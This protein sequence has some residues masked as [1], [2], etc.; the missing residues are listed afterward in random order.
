[1]KKF[2]L[3]I[4]LLI[5][6]G[7]LSAGMVGRWNFEGNLDNTVSG[8]DSM[9]LENVGLLSYAD[10]TIGGSTA[11][12][13]SFPAFTS[14]EWLQMPND[15]GTSPLYLWTLVMDVKFPVITGYSSFFQL[16]PA[17]DTDADFFVPSNGGGIG[18]G[19]NYGG[20][21]N[22]DTWYRIAV[23]VT[24]N[25]AGEFV[26]N[27]YIDGVNVGGQTRATSYTMKDVALLF[28]DESNETAA[29][30]VNSVALYNET[31][32]DTFINGLGAASV[33]GI[34]SGG[35]N[36]V[37]LWNFNDTLDNEVSNGNPIALGGKAAYSTETIGGGTADVLSFP[38]FSP[39]QWLQMPN[40]AAVEPTENYTL[41]MDVRFAGG[42]MCFYSGNTN[43]DSDGCIYLNTLGEIGLAGGNYGGTFDND[44]WYRFAIT[45]SAT[46]TPG[47]YD[48]QKWLDGTKVQGIITYDGAYGPRFVLKDKVLLFTDND[49]ETV[50]GAVN[51][52]ALWDEVMS[53]GFI[54]SIGGPSADGIPVPEP[55]SV[56]LI[57]TA[58]AGLLIRK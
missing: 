23:T 2:I 47:A 45:V 3:I 40:A 14:S 33:A 29:G 26:L 25:A 37:G 52:V 50:V 43:N 11:R 49:G 19:G 27:Y 56:I 16:N 28:T 55:A 46:G 4:T 31:K 9:S 13:L 42:W 12:V 6:A 51:S 35:A 53:D 39:S 18:I 10:N 20:T 24:T 41:I 34:S 54:S 17:N 1:M 30:M 32:D 15:S 44:T 21:F 58:L 5:V 7:T 38:P 57:L 8:G 48:T 22:Q 36:L